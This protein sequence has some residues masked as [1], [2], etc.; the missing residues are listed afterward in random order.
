MRSV[1]AFVAVAV[2]SLAITSAGCWNPFSPPSDDNPSGPQYY[3][4]CDSA[5]KVIAN[6]QTAYVARDINR[7]LDCFTSDFEFILLEVDWADYDGDGTIDHSWGLDTEDQFTDA[8]FDQVNHIELTMWGGFE[9]PWAGDSTGTTMDIGRQFDLKVYT[10]QA[11]T[12]GY[13]ATGQAE[14]YCTQDSTGQYR[15]WKWIDESEI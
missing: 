10:D 14:F 15:I 8:M 3:E 4:N 12:Q 5:W 6:L 13:R 2:L 1:G 9:Y 7:Y 11:G